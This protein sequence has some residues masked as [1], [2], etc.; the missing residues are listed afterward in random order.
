MNR[1][2]TIFSLSDAISDICPHVPIFAQTYSDILH[3]VAQLCSTCEIN[4]HSSQKVFFFI[5]S[6]LF[7]LVV[8]KGKIRHN[9]C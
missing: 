6:F 4:F 3:H 8:K 2:C 5:M 1:K 9:V 7:D